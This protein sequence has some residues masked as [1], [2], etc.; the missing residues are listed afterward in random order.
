M[1]FDASAQTTRVT[2]PTDRNLSPSPI[3]STHLRLFGKVTAAPANNHFLSASYRSRPNTDAFAGVGVNDSAAVATNIEG[4]NRVATATYSWFFS[5]TGYLDVKYLRL[6]EQNDTVA[7]TD[8]GFQ[9]AFDVNNLAAMGQFT[10]GGV[11]VGAANLKLNRQ[12]YARDESG[13][14]QPVP[15]LKGMS[16]QTRPLRIE[17]QE[18]LTERVERLG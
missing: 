14:G 18:D 6:D 16:H 5:S 12:N 7:I 13:H 1:F 15:R 9:P 4:T 3:A 11:N 17:A 10:V 8:F 2:P